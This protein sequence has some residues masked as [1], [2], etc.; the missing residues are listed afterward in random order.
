MN[1][2]DEMERLSIEQL[3]VCQDRASGLRAVIAVHSTKRGPALG[4]CR[5]WAY[6]SEQEAII[7]AMRLARGMTYKAAVFGLDYGGG[8]AVILGN[9][10]TDKSEALFKALG[11]YISYM[12]GR[13]ITGV[14]LGTTV[15]DMDGVGKETMYV[16]D[17]TGS[18]MATD[19]FTP[20]M[21]AYGV[22]LGMK[23]SAAAAFGS[24]SL[25][26]RKV[27]VQGLGKVGM[28]LCRYL[29]EAGAE[30]LV[31]DL[32]GGRVRSAAMAYSADIALPEA[33]M[34]EPCD[35]FAPCAMGG[36]LNDETI[37]KLRCAIVAG[38]ANNQLLEEAH[39][40]LLCDRGILY[41]PDYVINAGGLLITAREIQGGSAGDMM[42]SVEQIESVL[43]LVF[44]YAKSA[45]IPTNQAANRIAERNIKRA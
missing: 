33:I 9:P 35:I 43:R 5:M 7:D 30:L 13:Y 34:Q 21:T 19:D 14:D 4:G 25:Q 12:N 28:R 22:Y 44:R 10:E 36:L 31:A 6:K 24:S 37:P 17:T 23:A 45:G 41:A 39:G 15:T 11:R 1:V 29:H 27:A 20:E 3:V 40:Q 16:T 38:S 2:M 42:R 32:D 8:K 18:I 26:G